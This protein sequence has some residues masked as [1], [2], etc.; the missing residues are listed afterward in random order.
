MNAR[1]LVT[2]LG[3][4]RTAPRTAGRAA[5]AVSA[6]V[7][8]LGGVA[9]GAASTAGAAVTAGTT[10]AAGTSLRSANASPSLALVASAP[11]AGRPRAAC[12]PVAPGF[13]RC[14][15][16]YTPQTAV[17]RALAAG[18]IGPGGHT[19]GLGCEEHRVRLQ[20][21][22]APLLARPGRGGGRVR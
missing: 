19:A 1:K 12:P 11:Q 17:N 20:A 4:P 2:A 13:A 18:A 5:L 21:A 3:R 6:A 16:L 10:G 9:A 7:A 8:V 22:R 15:T 14:L